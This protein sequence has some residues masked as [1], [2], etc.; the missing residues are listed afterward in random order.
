MAFGYLD[1]EGSVWQGINHC[2]LD[3]DHIVFWN[4]LTSLHQRSKLTA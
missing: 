1:S 3:G 4:T 2:S